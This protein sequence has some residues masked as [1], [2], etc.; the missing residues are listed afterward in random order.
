MELLL[1]VEG[2]PPPPKMLFTIHPVMLLLAAK[3][4]SMLPVRCPVS[5]IFFI[6]SVALL[7]HLLYP[8]ILA[9]LMEM[10]APTTGKYSNFRRNIAS[11]KK[12]PHT[13]GLA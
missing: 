5:I 2:S 8:T 11:T 7:E 4:P 12:I 3:P 6:L 1:G 13:I 9:T 10:A